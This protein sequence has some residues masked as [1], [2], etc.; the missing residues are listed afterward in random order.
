MILDSLV[1]VRNVA[2]SKFLEKGRSANRHP[3]SVPLLNNDLVAVGAAMQGSLKHF[4][5]AARFKVRNSLQPQA[6]GGLFS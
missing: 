6:K 3:S 5:V 1:F 2:V 4:I